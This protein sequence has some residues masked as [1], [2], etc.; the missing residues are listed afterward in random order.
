MGR[1]S[2]FE[3]Q[4]D[5]PGGVYFGGNIVTGRVRLVLEGDGKKARGVHV[6][7][8]GDSTVRWR[9][10][11]S[12]HD[13]WKR[14]HNMGPRNMERRRLDRRGSDRQRR[15]FKSHESYVN[16]RVHLAGDGS[17]TQIP[18]GEHIY[19]FQFQLPLS[20]PSSFMGRYG[21]IVYSIKAVIDRPW[22]FDHETVTFFTVSGI[23]DLNTDPSA[24]L[25]FSKSDYKMLGL[26]CCQSG[27]ISASVQLDRSGYVP[28]ENIYLK[29]TADNKSDRVMNSTLV[30]L[31]QSTTYMAEGHK[32]VDDDIIF[33]HKKGSIQP[34]D[35]YNWEETALKIPPLPPSQLYT[36]TNIKIEYRIEFRVDPSG[37]SFDLCLLAPIV[38]GS[39][40]LRSTLKNFKQDPTPTPT[41]APVSLP[42]SA[43]P[44]SLYPELP[45]P[46]YQEATVGEDIPHLKSDEENEH[47]GGNWDY[48]PQYPLYDESSFNLY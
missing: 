45:P 2:L 33:E 40:P 42:P 18:P 6:T 12:H 5:N 10:M 29:A 19:H 39:I 4:L 38:I 35:S 14:N 11:E 23:Y 32:K 43:P 21:K 17:E 8:N 44:F 31:V 1:L 25:P 7:L 28:G 37:M 22:K 13:N 3:I 26:L 47:V 34:G 16:T 41:P 30:Y 20:L 48:K 27:P 36:C 24:V 15:T 9:E 46:T